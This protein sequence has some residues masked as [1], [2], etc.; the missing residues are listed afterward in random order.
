MPFAAP[1]RMQGQAPGPEPDSVG[2]GRRP[3]P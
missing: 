3:A 2:G 1:P